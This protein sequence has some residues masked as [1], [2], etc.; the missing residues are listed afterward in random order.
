MVEKLLSIIVPVYNVQGY[1]HDCIESLM[2]QNMD[3]HLYEIIL[4]NDGSNDK[5][6]EIVSSFSKL[7]EN[8]RGYHFENSG[9]GATRNKGIKLAKGKYIAFLDSDDFVPKKAYSSLI[10]SAEFNNAEIVTSPVERFEDGKY[11]RSGLHKKVDFTKKTGITLQENTSLF[12]DTTSTNKIYNREYLKKN[13]IYFP[14]KI[15]YEDIYFTMTAYSKAQTINIIENVTYIWRIRSGETISI[16]QD[17]FNIQSYKDRIGTCLNTLDFLYKNTNKIIAKEFEKRI[18]VFDIPLFFP[19]YLNVDEVYTK[20]FSSLTRQCL[21][22]LDNSLISYCDYRKQV[23][24]EA[25]KRE[26]DKTVLNYSLDH[27]KTMVLQDKKQLKPLDNYLNEEYLDMINFNYSDILKTKVLNVSSNEKEIIILISI[28]SILLDKIDYDA[29]Q[30]YVFNDFNE[31]KIEFEKNE[32]NLLTLN[33]NLEKITEYAKGGLSRVKL[34]YKKGEI[35]HEKILGEPGG[36]CQKTTLLKK[37]KN[38]NYRVNYSF[39]WDLF[40]EKQTIDNIFEKINIIGNQLIINTKKIDSESIFKLKNYRESAIT[41]TVKNNKIIFHLPSTMKPDRLFELSV[42]KNGV[43]SYNYQFNKLPKFFNYIDIDNTQEYVMRVYSNHSISINKKGKHSQLEAMK[44]EDGKLFINHLSPYTDLASNINAKL[45]L[46]STNGKVTKEF[47]CNKIKNNLYETVIELETDN[48]DHFLTYGS[49]L[50]SI[51]YYIEKQLLP[52]SLLLNERN[53]VEFPFNF[54][55]KNREYNF[56]SKNG[57]L[58]YLNKKQ[59]FN[60]VENS[61]IK[62]RNIY[63]YLYPLFRLLPKDRKKIIYYSYWGEQYACSPKA[64]Y[65]K[66]S[67]NKKQFKN[68]WILN[69]TNLPIEGNAIKIKKNSLKYWYHLATSKYFVQNTNMPVWYKKRKGQLE[70]QTFHGTFMKTMGFDTPEFKFE[71]RQTKID[72]FQKKVNNW[73]YV[74]VPSNYMGDKA[75]SAFN[76]K[77]KQINS[78]FPRNDLIFDALNYVDKTKKKLNIPRGKKI[79]LYAPTWRESKSSDIKMNIEK[80]QAKLGREYVLL[81]RAHYMVSNN[82]DIRKYYPFAINVSNYSSIEE[83]YSISDILITDYSSVMFDYA[84]LKRPMIFYAYD[85]EKYLHGE[86]GTYLDYQKIVPGAVARTTDEIV[87]NLQN[88]NLLKEVYKEKYDEFYKL[89]CRYGRAGDSANEVINKF[90]KSK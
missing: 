16:S 49:Y 4:L 19:D 13:N 44:Y 68:I 33:I 74:S 2:E 43:E 90:I 5:S 25:I 54:K 83:L 9:L 42:M 86:R 39:G 52:E 24:Y 45:I 79:I 46:K 27:V 47:E 8:I 78:G 67:E 71:T 30:A 66:V 70:I 34:E 15:V 23:I 50:F 55:F 63:K 1:L 38:S 48:I 21:L 40:I 41:S 28:N 64:I 7:Y 82:M 59:I 22:N 72:E 62:R 73:D 81:I 51:D 26:D 37:I 84:Y 29:I 69:D 31:Q 32:K 80:L 17:R 35:T 53:K 11:T 58:I 65:R 12:Y 60:K 76:T 3:N 61:K 75:Q 18:I 87:N 36:T 77:V 57:H 85:L 20:E 89:F 10:E 14:E 88:L 56:K 6:G